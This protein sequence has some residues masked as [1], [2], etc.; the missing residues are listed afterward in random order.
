MRVVNGV[1]VLAALLAY[2][3][4]GGTGTPGG[5]GVKTDKTDGRT[6]TTG[7]TGPEEGTFTIKAPLLSTSI[8]QGES[9]TITLS[10]SRG[11]NFEENV[12]LKF[13]GVPQGVTIEPANP[14]IP[15]DEKE[16]KLT[17]KAGANAALG[18]HTV[19]IT[20][21]ATRGKPATNKLELNIDKA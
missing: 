15:H 11:K 3:G 20:G 16:V 4:C 12:T 6:G 21:E 7:L 18:K 1:L 13:D 10:L 5:P 9:K 19:T 2:A 8:K 17:I 14:K